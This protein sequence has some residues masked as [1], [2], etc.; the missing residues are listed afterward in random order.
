MN[1]IGVRARPIA[2]RRYLFLFLIAGIAVGIALAFFAAK[3]YALDE[4]GCLTCH[5]K[6]GMTKTNGNGQAVSLYVSEKLVNTAAHR[7]IDCTTCHTNDP[8]KVATPLTKLSLAQKCG[9]CHQYEYKV[10]LESVHGQQ[11]AQ[12]NP[13]VAT[14]VDCHSAEGSPHS[15]VRVLEYQATAYKKNIA[16]TCAK[17]H[18]NEALM[19]DY[20][21]VEKVYESYMRSYH[22]KAIELGSYEITQLDEA[23][24]TN[25]HGTH[26]IKSASDPTSPVAGLDNLANTCEKCHPGAGVQFASSF[27]GHR[28]AS[29][30]NI[31]VAHYTEI[32]FKTLLTSVI[33]FGAIVV[34]A[35][36]VRYSIN[37]WRE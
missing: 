20:G 5:G 9:T 26:D 28:E 4:K 8:H 25:C 16:A 36:M 24:C 37:R 35:A 27:L 7:Y 11:L 18:D 3:A 29:P 15:V 13:D 22:G 14:C 6:P 33:S 34:V 10:H 2:S 21:V 23:T 32:L 19:A 31:P 17:C 12:G 30:E 1:E